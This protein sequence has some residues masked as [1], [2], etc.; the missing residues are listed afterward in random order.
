MISNCC[1]ESAESHTLAWDSG[2]HD[3]ARCTFLA[4][5]V[6]THVLGLFEIWRPS[7]FPPGVEH[8]ARQPINCT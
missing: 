8:V 7:Y 2:N 3:A 6:K 1:L 5:A 4:N